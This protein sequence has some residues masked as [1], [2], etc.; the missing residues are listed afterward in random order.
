MFIEMF[1]LYVKNLSYWSNVCKETNKS[2]KIYTFI[3][4][5]TMSNNFYIP[6]FMIIEKMSN[7]KIEKDE[8]TDVEKALDFLFEFYFHKNENRRIENHE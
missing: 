3:P 1:D 2:N 5:V 7:G 4:W 8:I 6:I